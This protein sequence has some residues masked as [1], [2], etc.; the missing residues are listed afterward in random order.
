MEVV[1]EEAAMDIRDFIRCMFG[2]PNDQM[3]RAMIQHEIRM[4]FDQHPDID[5]G[6][7]QCN[8]ANNFPEA[9]MSGK[10]NVAM[11]FTV[12]GVLFVG[13]AQVDPLNQ[14][15]VDAEVNFFLQ[16]NK[17]AL[18]TED[19]ITPHH[20]EGRGSRVTTLPGGDDLAELADLQYFQAKLQANLKLPSMEP[21]MPAALAS[22]LGY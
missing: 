14:S 16:H 21:E 10:L 5:N 19:F 1:L 20:R 3:T 12:D 17:P 11:H 18:V 4:Y 8:D 7:C 2:Q 13:A 9:V 15:V 6:F 22:T